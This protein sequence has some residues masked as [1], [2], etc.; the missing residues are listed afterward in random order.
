MQH[1]IFLSYSH[2]DKDIMNQ[3]RNEFHKA[4][5]KVWTD[6]DIEQGAPSWQKPIEA[7]IE[8]SGCIVVICSPDSKRSKWVE[9][10][11]N[12]GEMHKKRIF[13]ILA[14]GEDSESIPL[15]ISGYKYIDIREASSYLI[16]IM[17][18]TSTICKTLDILPIENFLNVK[19]RVVLNVSQSAE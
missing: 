10:E 18:L 12:Y 11:L 3:V 15:I 6:E 19:D 13:P 16:N 5:L 17:R 2:K 9:R 7:T 14:R 4:G 1:H 8:D